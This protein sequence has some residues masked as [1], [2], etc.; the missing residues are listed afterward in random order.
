[1]QS[2][3]GFPKELQ[4]EIDMSLPPGVSSYAVKV[5]PSN[6]SQVQSATQTLTASSTLQLNG[7]SSNVIFDI[8][9]GQGKGKFIDPRFSTLSFRVNYEI[10]NTPSAAIISN[11]QLR[12]GAHSHWDRC[13]IQS[14]NGVVLDDVN[15]FG[16]VQDMLTQLEIDV[17][18][19]DSLAAMYGFQFE[20]QSSGLNVN[21]G[22]VL[23]NIDG[24]TLAAASSNYYSYAIPLMSSLIGKG[25]RKYFQ[26]GA[27]SKLQLV[28]QSSAIIP[29]T[30]VTSTATTQATFRITI[31]NMSLDLQY[32]DIGDEGVKMLGK[33]GLQYYDGTSYRVSSATLPSTA[34]TVSL[35]TGLRGSSVRALFMRCTEASTLSTAG[36]I[37]QI[38]DSK[39]P[40]ATSVAWNLNGLVV[41]SNPVDFMRNPAL[42]MSYTQEANASFNT[43][44][45]KS[46]LVPS[47][48]F[49][50]VPSATTVAADTDQVVL[51]A[52]T[53]TSVASQSQFLWGYNLEKISKFG[54]MSGAN[55]NSGNAFLNMTL[56]NASS[57]TLT[58]FFIAK[59][60]IIYVHDTETGSLES[61]L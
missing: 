37:N 50:Y 4:N 16:L 24:A 1:M 6:V 31:D 58:F 8:P 33:S 35:L 61:R 11:A 10:V 60:D 28:L 42:T 43:H 7:T 5:L 54:L 36:C 26:I 44:E 55:L 20:T 29:I 30:F 39:M 56:A 23:R 53:A 48:Y 19:K 41:P 57:N 59:Q 2:S 3:I 18:Q 45:F 17:A 22:H 46:G 51:A 15:N 27:T 14:Q 9:A 25:A 52:G 38:Y 21:Q 32:I 13:Y 47:R 49:V 40:Q 34:G 12:G